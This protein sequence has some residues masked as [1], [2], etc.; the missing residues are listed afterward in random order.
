MIIVNNP[1]KTS[2]L[3]NPIDQTKS[4]LK[5]S[6]GKKMMQDEIHPLLV[7]IISISSGITYLL[8]QQESLNDQSIKCNDQNKY[9]L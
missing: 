6:V 4:L 8:Y 7:S 9:I 1:W 3:N 5:Y 2:Q